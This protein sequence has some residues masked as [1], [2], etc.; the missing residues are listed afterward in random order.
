MYKNKHVTSIITSK[1]SE[2]EL[3][4]INLF[5]TIIFPQNNERGGSPDM[6]HTK[7]SITQKELLLIIRFLFFKNFL[8]F[9]IRIK[10]EE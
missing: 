10:A 9:I 8:C 3:K 2:G 6:L 5:I 7:V 4:L 1:I